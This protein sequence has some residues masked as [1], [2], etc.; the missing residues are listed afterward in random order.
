MEQCVQN[1]RT[2]PSGVWVMGSKRI[3]VSTPRT[4]IFEPMRDTSVLNVQE[5]NEYNTL[6][7]SVR[8]FLSTPIKDEVQ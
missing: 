3:R 2:Y 8:K 7:I 4:V 6:H 1:P 5:D